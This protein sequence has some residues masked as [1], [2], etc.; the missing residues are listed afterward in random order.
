MVELETESDDEDIIDVDKFENS[1]YL[2]KKSK[3]Q[4]PTSL[5]R[6]LLCWRHLFMA[7]LKE[8]VDKSGEF[9]NSENL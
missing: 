9:E 3:S 5:L 7:D 1:D 8:A 2:K 4:C 6:V